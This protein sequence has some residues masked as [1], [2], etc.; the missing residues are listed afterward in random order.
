MGTD[1]HG[2]FQVKRDGRWYDVQSMFNE[3]RHYFLFAWL[4]GVRNGYGFAGIKTHEPLVP[5]SEPKGYPEDFEVDDCNQYKIT[6]N[7]L[8][9]KRAEWYKDEDAN[10]GDPSHLM[11]W[12]GDH[13]HSWLSSGEILNAPDQGTR[14]VGAIALD[15]YKTWTGGSPGP[16][17]GDISGPDIVTVDISEE[18]WEGLHPDIEE[19]EGKTVYV[20]VS[21]K[22]DS[23]REACSEFIDEVKRLVGLHGEVRYVFGFDS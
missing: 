17:F 21:W 15:A 4:A 8:R 12:M 5:L 10:P 9:G 16:W 23:V 3:N 2:I 6:D 7:A 13:S 22:V 19:P 20:R 11:L 18:T 14:K 1:I